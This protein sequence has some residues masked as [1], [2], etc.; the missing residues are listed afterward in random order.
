MSAEGGSQCCGALLRRNFYAVG[1]LGVPFPLRSEADR[2]QVLSIVIDAAP[3]AQTASIIS[4]Q[5][6]YGRFPAPNL[7]HPPA[8]GIVVALNGTPCL[9]LNFKL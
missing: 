1:T 7:S 4:R 5:T 6:V 3:F 2:Q 8:C 9:S